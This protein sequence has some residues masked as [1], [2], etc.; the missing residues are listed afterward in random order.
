MLSC[1]SLCFWQISNK[2]SGQN[3]QAAHGKFE[4]VARLAA[5]CLLRRLRSTIKLGD[6]V[7]GIPVMA[8]Q[9]AYNLKIRSTSV[10]FL[11]LGT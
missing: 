5:K 6:G 8:N 11:S 4:L 7:E 2:I 10:Y 1:R 3:Q 9:K